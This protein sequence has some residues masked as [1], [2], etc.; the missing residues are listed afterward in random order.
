LFQNK[1]TIKKKYNMIRLLKSF[2]FFKFNKHLVGTEFCGCLYGYL[3]LKVK[4]WL[5]ARYFIT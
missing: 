4:H 5:L 1:L 2:I 3:Y